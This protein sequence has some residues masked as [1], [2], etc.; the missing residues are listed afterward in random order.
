MAL[1]AGTIEGESGRRLV[2][3]AAGRL[4][5][6]LRVY[7]SAGV[8]E[9]FAA[10]LMPETDM[11]Q[12]ESVSKRLL[13]ATLHDVGAPVLDRAGVASAFGAVEGGA[14]ALVDA[15]KLALSRAA[16]N[17]VVASDVFTGK[18][19]ILVVDDDRTFATVLAESLMERGWDAEPCTEVVDAEARI[20]EFHYHGYF[21]DVV[22]GS[23]RTGLD[24]LKLATSRV[25]TPPVV[26]MSGHNAAREDILE[27]LTLGPVVFIKKPLPAK[28]LGAAL[29][30]FRTLLS[31]SGLER[32]GRRSRTAD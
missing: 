14:E 2:Q 13:V 23:R 5:A 1:M 8:H 15:A 29:D 17:E 22:L 20:R 6:H 28:E 7:D 11:S 32:G 12:A 9:T 10:V 26:L 25:P 24:L 21:F 31:G 27:A 4:G 30:M 3:A 19:R 16:P 18:P